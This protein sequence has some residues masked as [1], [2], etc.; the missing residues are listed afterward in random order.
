ML[1]PESVGLVQQGNAEIFGVT[2]SSLSLKADAPVL[3]VVDGTLNMQECKLTGGTGPALTIIGQ[4]NV[5]LLANVILGNMGG[6]I[7][8]QGGTLDMRRNVVVR[9]AVAG[10]LLAPSKPGAI[11]RMTLWHDVILDNW[12]GYRCQAF[13]KSG[14]VPLS[15][16]ETFRIEASILNSGGMAEAFSDVT[17][18]RIRN[19]GYNFVSTPPLPI[20]DF[21]TNYD[22][23]DFRP[24][25]ALKTDELGVELGAWPTE[26]GMGQILSILNIALTTA[27]LREAYL[28]SAFLSGKDREAVS[29]R[30]QELVAYWTAEFL[31]SGR[32]GTRLVTILNLAQVAPAAWRMDVIL[33]RFMEGFVGR[34]TYV[35]KP[36]SFFEDN[37]AVSDSAFD[38]LQDH[39]AAFPRFLTV[40]GE[41]TNAFV[42]SGRISLPIKVANT[43]SPFK[44]EETVTNPQ[45][46]KLV[47]ALQLANS[48]RIETAKKKKETEDT[49]NSPH[50]KQKVGENSKHMANLKKQLAKFA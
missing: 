3:G 14:I 1:S 22:M 38:F 24:K 13:A 26:T 9:N 31:Q 23:E 7:R 35:L 5:Y 12:A 10:I 16:Q 34:Y 50:F 41:L 19:D 25:G 4:S 45:Y 8:L 36:L 20:A 48:R 40:T 2:L 17:A 30:I 6:G 39:L 21:F 15:G 42:L 44:L 18:Q 49:I 29:R 27:R 33:Q 43:A 32:L 37:A 46:P 11:Q 47:E 28:L